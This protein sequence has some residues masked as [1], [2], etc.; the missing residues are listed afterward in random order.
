MGYDLTLEISGPTDQV[1][2]SYRSDPP[3]PT[4]DILS[5]LA[6]GYSRRLQEFAPEAK[7][8]FSS[9]SASALLSQALSSQVTGR[10][11]R[12]FGVSRVKLSPNSQQLGT[13]GGPV[14]TI[15]QQLSPQ[16]PL[17]YETTTANSQYRVF[18]FEW[19]VSPR[20]SVRGFRDQN[21]IFGLE[22]K[23]RKRFK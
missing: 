5:L 4:A 15:E 7:N 3:L 16:L 18:E 21:G 14:L 23:F 20:M 6:F 1:R 22:L 2:L 19:T 11:Q 8:P 13:L 17:T 12:L 9:A 10:V